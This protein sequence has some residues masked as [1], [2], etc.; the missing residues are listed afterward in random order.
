MSV[1]INI[2]DNGSDSCSTPTV[3]EDPVIIGTDNICTHMQDYNMI[4]EKVAFCKAQAQ[5]DCHTTCEWKAFVCFKN[6]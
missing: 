3:P 5:A 1:W 6:Q 4:K 2:I